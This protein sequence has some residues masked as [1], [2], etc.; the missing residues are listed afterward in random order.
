MMNEEA[1]V[2]ET[3]LFVAPNTERTHQITIYANSVQTTSRNNMMILPVPNPETVKFIDLSNYSDIF[4]DLEKSFKVYSQSYGATNGFMSKGMM[5]NSLPVVSVGSYNATLV[6]DYFQIDRI[7]EDVFGKISPQMEKVLNKYYKTM[8]FVVCKLKPSNSLV[9]YHPF[10]YSHKIQD[11][12]KLFL[13]TRHQHHGQLEEINSHWDHSIY[14]FNTEQMSGNKPLTDKKIY[15]AT[16]KIPFNFGSIITFNKC[17]IQGNRKNMDVEFELL[18][19]LR[20]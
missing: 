6:P 2:A 20:T 9:K 10:A 11:S 15:L 13:P 14:S 7:D 5:R 19:P 8:G 17:S 4:K 3:E 12:G 1:D 18:S 16:E